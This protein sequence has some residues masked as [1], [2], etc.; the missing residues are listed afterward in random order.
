M[1]SPRSI[2][3]LAWVRSGPPPLCGP[4]AFAPATPPV[5]RLRASPSGPRTVRAVDATEDLSHELWTLRE[6]LEQ[7]V[8][9]LEVQT[10]LLSAGRAR[11]IPFASAEIEAIIEAV[12]EVE[13]ARE[14]AT[15]RVTAQRGL[16]PTASLSDLAAHLGAPW[17]PV[18]NQHR[19]HLLS[20]QAEVEELSRSNH[21]LARRRH[22][23]DPRGDRCARR[24]GARRVRPERPADPAVRQRAPT[25][26]DGVTCRTSRRS[27]RRSP[28]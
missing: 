18:F 23:A 11:W 25:R 22:D 21:D 1:M 2:R 3:A 6:L 8:F 16:P 9:K 19:L 14:A 26:S 7:L 28:G 17:G 12:A 27:T 4:D 24:T 5:R 10:L 20:L 13:I 15:R